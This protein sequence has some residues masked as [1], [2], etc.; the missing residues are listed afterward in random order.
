MQNSNLSSKIFPI[1]RA[2]WVDF[3]KLVEK[4]L[5]QLM[6]SYNHDKRKLKDLERL[7][8]KIKEI[9]EISKDNVEEILNYRDLFMYIDNSLESSFNALKFFKEKDNF[10][11][12]AVKE[13]FERIIHSQEIIVK[14]SEYNSLRIKVRFCGDRIKVLNDLIRGSKVDFSL[15]KELC[16]KYKIDEGKR[17][18]ILFY[19]VVMLAIKQ[20]DLKATKEE[21]ENEKKEFYQKRF[22][23]LSEKYHNMKDEY[24]E[25]RNLCF[26]VREKMT[27]RELD[28]YSPYENKPS[29]SNG[30]N[31]SDETKFKIWTLAFFKI[32]KDIEDYIAGISDLIKDCSDL[33]DELAYFN[34]LI[35]DF[36]SIADY[37]IG[38]IPNN[39]EMDSE[40]ENSIYFALDSFNRV[41]IDEIVN[42]RNLSSI[43]ALIEKIVN[44]SNSKIEGVKTNHM[45]GVE[46]EEKLLGKNI[47]MITTSK[48]KLAYVM[49]GKSILIIAGCDV[50]DRID[51]AVRLAVKKN[52]FAIKKQISEIEQED[53]D[54]I[55]LQNEIIG[56][57]KE[58]KR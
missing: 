44:V 38:L 32:K 21:K 3:I 13:I 25:L 33:D 5:E 6:N 47:S 51:I 17:K 9:T 14:G 37:L 55:E 53:A 2:D 23:E 57:I 34:V 31:N 52:L 35:D 24:K 29:E 1:I 56:N 28:M 18:N 15:I 11:N 20:K 46:N 8:N 45:L 7:M 58:H 43:K 10:D 16:D 42:D 27:R 54:Y 30:N 4:E 49:V 19:P 48:V 41:I 36:Q 50:T 12:V 40:N 39:K 26:N 22:N